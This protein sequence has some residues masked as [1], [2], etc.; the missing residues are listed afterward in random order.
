MSASLSSKQIF[1]GVAFA[2]VATMLWAGNYI[3][4]RGVSHQVL[5]FTLAF[6]RWL[7][8]SIVIL[9]IAW[10]TMRT[11]LPLLR[12][13]FA[14]FLIAAITG[15]TLFNSFL[16]I[17]GHYSTAINLALISTTSAPIFII[18]LA[19]IFLKEPI[20]WLR[21]VGLLFCIAGILY[22]LSQGSRE[23]LMQLKF[24]AGDFWAL[25]GAFMFALYSVL[26]RKKPAGISGI[27]FLGYTFIIG[28]IFLVPFYIIEQ[29]SY[30]TLPLN[31]TIIYSVLYIGTAASIISYFCWNAAISRLG[32]SRTA[33]FTNLIPVFS[34][35]EASLLLHE[36]ITGFH[37][38]SFVLVIIGLV[39]AN[40]QM[41]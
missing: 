39:L 3:I 7:V 20:G 13:Y 12:K 36:Q 6:Y 28:T 11:E 23:N 17:G 31:S 15:V 29:V 30:P 8:A 34:T 2:V 26:V 27:S 1:T 25:L 18:L 21:A 10:K 4:A 35:I 24:A 40:I 19:R 22:L 37:I 41:K 14:F 5:P 9:P 33:L 32:A 16:Y 38:I